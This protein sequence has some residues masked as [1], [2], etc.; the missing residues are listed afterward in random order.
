MY[1]VNSYQLWLSLRYITPPRYGSGVLRSVCLSV[2]V[3]V[4]PRAYLWNRWTDFHEIFVQIPCGRISVLLGQRCDTL[5]TSGFMDDVTFGRSG[6]YGDACMEGWTFNLLPLAALRY[7]GGVS[8]LW[9]PCLLLCLSPCNFYF[10]IVFDV[11]FDLPV[12]LFLYLYY[13]T[14][15]V[16]CNSAAEG[17]QLCWAIVFLAVWNFII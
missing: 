16:K 15:T 5:R 9:M 7:R 10:L 14:L 4:Y 2:C 8:C 12:S 1:I 17:G 3:A 13:F 6:P 11:I